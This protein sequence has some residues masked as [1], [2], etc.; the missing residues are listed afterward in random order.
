VRASALRP[1]PSGTAALRSRVTG[2]IYQGGH[3]RVDAEV[4]AGG[5]PALHLTLPEP[6]T[7]VEGAQIDLAIDDGWVVPRRGRD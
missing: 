5:R 2:M 4:E 7:V 6:S 1:V 3:F